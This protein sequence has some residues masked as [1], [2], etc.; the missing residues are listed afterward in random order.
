MAGKAGEREFQPRLLRQ[1]RKAASQYRMVVEPDAE[2]LYLGRVV[3]LPGVLADGPGPIEC[4]RSLMFA[5]ETTVASMLADGLSPPEA[6]S[7]ARRRE[8]INIR[9]TPEEKAMLATASKRKGFRGV[10]EFVRSAALRAS[11]KDSA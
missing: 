11:L 7:E 4:L 8:Q 5:A 9:L 3:E 1:A 6:A 10:S 2:G